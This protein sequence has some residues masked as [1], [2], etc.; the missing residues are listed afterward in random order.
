MLNKY[1][2][3]LSVGFCVTMQA[4]QP[5]R[6]S[7]QT[8][9]LCP[10]P[11]G[12]VSPEKNAHPVSWEV[13]RGDSPGQKAGEWGSGGWILSPSTCFPYYISFAF[14]ATLGNSKNPGLSGSYGT[15]QF[16]S[17]NFIIILLCS[18]GLLFKVS[19]LL[20]TFQNFADNSHLVSSPLLFCLCFCVYSFAFLNCPF[21]GTWNGT[22]VKASCFP[23][24]R[25]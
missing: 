18:H 25:L 23:N 20:F 24:R 4:V 5:W 14:A 11:P 10:T 1:G 9:T 7:R 22:H 15:S 6:W 21:E 16:T 19:S 2:T 3:L 12:S 13:E 8:H 17:R